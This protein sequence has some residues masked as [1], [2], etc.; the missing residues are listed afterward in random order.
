M[1]VFAS[2]IPAAADAAISHACVILAMTPNRGIGIKGKM[3]WRLSKELKYFTEVTKTVDPAIAAIHPSAQNVVIMGKKTY[4]S[5][6]PK[7]RS[8]PG[9]VVVVVTH[10]T[11]AELDNAPEDVF[12]TNEDFF[13]KEGH[14]YPTS[15][16]EL[17]SCVCTHF[18]QDPEKYGTVFI[19]GGAELYNTIMQPDVKGYHLLPKKVYLSTIQLDN[20]VECDTFV[21]EAYYPPN[22]ADYTR[23]IKGEDQTEKDIT[24][25]CDVYERKD[26][27]LSHNAGG[28]ERSIKDQEE[29]IEEVD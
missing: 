28:G 10:S 23:I 8:L 24:F 18:A 20:T 21:N 26:I 29:K 15:L 19:A 6:S 3:P 1:S 7:F 12:I 22:E 14:A 4:L 5:V 16:A 27:T 17:L 13:W 25:S 9:R 11:R 2:T